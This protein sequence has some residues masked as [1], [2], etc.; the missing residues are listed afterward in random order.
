MDLAP[1][2]VTAPN[3]VEYDR[4]VPTPWKMVVE[5]RVKNPA[6]SWKE[7]AKS[8]GYSHQTVLCWTK[9]AEFQRYENFVLARILPEVPVRVEMERRA[10][11]QRVAD[12]FET[13]A[14][15]MQERLLVLLETVEDPKLQAQIAQ[16]WLDRSGAGVQKPSDKRG[17]AL[18]M[19]DEVMSAFFTRAMEAG[20]IRES[21]SL[22][23]NT[24]LIPAQSLAQNTPSALAV[25]DVGVE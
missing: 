8:V 9:K 13:H 18:V 7:I 21:G 10:T 17:F 4:V 6:A 24:A 20:I 15:E 22:A 14:E 19:S 1:Q 12:R 3:V 2:P 23:Q 16:D 25:I 5:L 11:M